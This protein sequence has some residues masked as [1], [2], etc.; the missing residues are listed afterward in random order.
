M[1]QDTPSEL[2]FRARCE[3]LGKTVV[4]ATEDQNKYEHI[5][6][7]VDGISV[8]VKGEKKENRYDKDITKELIWLEFKNVK[9]N[10]GWMNSNVQKI[11]FKIGESYYV[12]DRKILLKFCNEFIKDRNIYSSAIEK[13]HPGK[14]YQRPGKRDLIS[15]LFLKDIIHLLEYKI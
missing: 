7:F 11:A 9:G 14:L 15:F 6:F 1:Y 2:G 8:D 3:H 10:K 5:D 4:K 12:F 13:K